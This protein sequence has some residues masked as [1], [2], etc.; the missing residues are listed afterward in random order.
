MTKQEKETDKYTIT[1]VEFNKSLS[2][3]DKIKISVRI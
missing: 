1:E 2:E 3:V